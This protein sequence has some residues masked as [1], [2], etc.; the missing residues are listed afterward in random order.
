MMIFLDIRE[1]RD[2][3]R[4]KEAF[5]QNRAGQSGECSTDFPMKEAKRKEQRRIEDAP[6]SLHCRPTITV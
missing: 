6:P 5:L 1:M 2:D 3:A 4:E